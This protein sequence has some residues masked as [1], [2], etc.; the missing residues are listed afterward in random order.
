[1]ICSCIT[2]S[3][4][5]LIGK[6]HNNAV[7]FL[8]K[9]MFT[10][11]VIIDKVFTIHASREQLLSC[12]KMVEKSDLIIVIGTDNPKTNFE[13]KNAIADHLRLK[14]DRND[15]AVRAV[16]DYFTYNKKMSVPN[17]ENEFYLP[18]TAMCLTNSMSYLQGFATFRDNVIVYLPDDLESVKFLY[19][20]S[21]FPIVTKELKV[22][23]DAILVYNMCARGDKQW[24][25]VKN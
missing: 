10:M 13:I 11:G 18:S 15:K 17:V 23:Y 20:N 6:S 5:S 9:S 1:M 14:M 2:L 24:P 19:N 16:E 7:G 8:A 25:L 22:A 3:E 21:L 12:L 4:N